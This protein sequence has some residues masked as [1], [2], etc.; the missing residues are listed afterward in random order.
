MAGADARRA[1]ERRGRR[2]ETLALWYLRAKG[3]RLLGSRYKTPV[4]EIDLI[5]SRGRTIAFVEVKARPTDAEA[6][7]AATPTGRRR[8]ARAA[9][10]WLAAHPAAAERTLR[11]DVIIAV[12]GRLPRHIKGAFDADGAA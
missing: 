7:E 3:Y 6:A 1:A 11:L 5:V 10:M 4:G 12:P 8:V 2:A 9:S